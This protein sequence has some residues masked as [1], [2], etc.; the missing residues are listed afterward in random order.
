MHS[1]FEQNYLN[2]NRSCK[3]VKRKQKSGVN[4]VFLFLFELFFMVEFAVK[5]TSSKP[6]NNQS[7]KG[8]VLRLCWVLSKPVIQVLSTYTK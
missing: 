6:I 8:K 5:T 3:F 1:T 4:F 2:P 7:D